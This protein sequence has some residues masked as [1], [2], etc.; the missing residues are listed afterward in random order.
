MLL[1]GSYQMSITVEVNPK[2]ELMNSILYTSNHSNLIKKSMGFNPMIDFQNEYTE[3]VKEY[4]YPYREHEIY[5]LVEKMTINGFFL[6]R[7]MELMCSVGEFPSLNRKHEISPLCRELCGGEENI[8]NLLS[9]LR[10]FYQEIDY[11]NFFDIVKKYYRDYIEAVKR[12]INKY[13]F[14]LVMEEFYGKKQNSYHYIITNLSHGSFGISFKNNDKLDM[15]AIMTLMSISD[16]EEEN[17][18]YRG[19]LSTNTTIHEFAH[20]LINPLTEKFS[21][22]V[23]KYCQAYEWLKKYKLP[24]FQSGYGDWDECVNEHIVRAIAIY[25]AAKLGEKE[26]ASKH[27]DY[28]MK[29]GYKYLPALLDKFQ[30]YEKHRDIYKTINDFYPELIEV[31]AEKV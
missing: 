2:I 30:Y 9:L 10:R 13:P 4:F 20:P 6:G 12:H 21:D 22:L 25:L 18:L 28:D 16:N 8:N 24:N 23:K 26:Y 19:A 31:F 15:F 17:E 11:M 5:S 27:L 14:V 3:I 1:R 29:I 7:P